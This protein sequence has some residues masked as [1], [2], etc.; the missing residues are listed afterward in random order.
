VA[1]ARGFA[2]EPSLLLCDEVTSALDVSVQA[3]V[4]DLLLQLKS[5]RESTLVFVSHDLA[6][7]RALSDRVAILYRGRVC[8]QGTVD[9]VYAPPF[10]PYTEALLSAVL[11]PG[12]GSAANG[13]VGATSRIILNDAGTIAAT[14]TGCPFAAR[15]PRRV[16]PICDT[17]EP[18]WQV[19]LGSHRLRCHIPVAT[20]RMMQAVGE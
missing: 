14:A 13:A 5:E 15:C 6:V 3:A 11:D 17:Q 18:P 8:E 19:G 4:I 16:G 10:H 12:P 1:I 7:V 9:E 2:A 20:L